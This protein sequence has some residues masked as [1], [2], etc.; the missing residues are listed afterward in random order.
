M[1]MRYFE[2]EHTV[3]FQETNLIGNVYYVHYLSWQGRCREMFLHEHAPSVLE[4]IANGLKL[5]TVRVNCEY[6][7]E[8]LAFDKVSIR[9]S[10]VT[11]KPSGMTL[12]FTYV[13]REPNRETVVARGEMEIACLRGTAAVPVPEEL[14]EA[15][16]PYREEAA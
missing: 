5:A 11:L 1:D 8:L 6:E 2:Y 16:R 7:E 9:M 14:R 15:L 4:D 12:R 13:K 3:G 10:L